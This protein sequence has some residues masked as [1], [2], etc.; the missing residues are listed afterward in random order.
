MFDVLSDLGGLIEIIYTAAAVVAVLF[1][2]A[3]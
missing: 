3:D 1:N 2:T